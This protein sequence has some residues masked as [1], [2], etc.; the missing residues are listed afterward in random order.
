MQQI[1]CNNLKELSSVEAA[2]PQLSEKALLAVTFS[3]LTGIQWGCSRSL[4]LVL[5]AYA[6]RLGGQQCSDGI[7]QRCRGAVTTLP[8]ANDLAILERS[9]VVPRTPCAACRRPLSILQGGGCPATLSALIALPR[10]VFS[11]GGSWQVWRPLLGRS[12]TRPTASR[13]R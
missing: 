10:S 5:T 3:A 11:P 4:S 13:T 8:K 9:G 6:N 2:V 12:C 7:N 1:K